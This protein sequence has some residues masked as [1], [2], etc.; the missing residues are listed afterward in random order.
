MPPKLNGVDLKRQA[1]CFLEAASLL[2]VQGGAGS[3]SHSW[4]RA[5]I[6]QMEEGAE[7]GAQ[8]RTQ[9]QKRRWEAVEQ[10]IWKR[11]SHA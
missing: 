7:G 8:I 3:S 11:G 9:M 6:V 10:R 5:P 4:T 1:A 2:C